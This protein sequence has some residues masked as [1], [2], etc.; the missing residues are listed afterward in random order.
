MSDDTSVPVITVD[1]DWAHDSTA[2]APPA[3]NG[4]LVVKTG[5]ANGWPTYRV[6][7]PVDRLVAWLAESY[8]GQD[9]QEAADLGQVLEGARF[10]KMADFQGARPL[11]LVPAG[12]R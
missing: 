2:T 7:A 8:L 4:L 5:S 1:L 6:T 12:P 11:P 3:A 10:A 9:G